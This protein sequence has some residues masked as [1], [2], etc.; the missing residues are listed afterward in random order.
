MLKIALLQIYILIIYNI[1]II[2]AF[3][4]HYYLLFKISKN[5]ISAVRIKKYNYPE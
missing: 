4:K 5:P 3:I 2:F 1:K